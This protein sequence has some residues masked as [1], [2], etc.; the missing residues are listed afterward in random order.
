MA[1]L[2]L[3]YEQRAAAWRRPRLWL[4]VATVV[5]LVLSWQLLYP[6][7]RY[8]ESERRR[9][10]WESRWYA[11]SLRHVDPPTK[12]KYTENS[13]D[14]PPGGFV[15]KYWFET[16]HTVGYQS[17][18]GTL[19]DDKPHHFT[20][21][22]P[23]GSLPGEVNL[24]SHERTSSEGDSAL[25]IVSDPRFQQDGLA[26]PWQLVGMRDGWPVTLDQNMELLKT[27]GI[28]DPH[29]IRIY[30]GQPDPNDRS[31][32]GIPF[33]A[34]GRRGWI[35][36]VFTDAGVKLTIRLEPATRPAAP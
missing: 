6:Q 7:V 14:A 24:F 25:L 9:R 28:V 19:F 3:T 15:H 17:Y 34:R 1:A 27:A 20:G 22:S 31:R 30:A 13:A 8:W 2:P 29:E 12:L 4:L 26:V 36:G 5:A 23:V 21:W 16:G 11:A 32:F 35:D 18:G 33:E 10:R